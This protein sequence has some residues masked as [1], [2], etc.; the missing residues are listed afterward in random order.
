MTTKAPTTT[1]GGLSVAVVRKRIKNLHVGVYPPEGR[2]RVAAPLALSEEAVRLAVIQ[3]SS[4]IK[5]QQARF[6]AQRRQSRREFVSGESHYFLG[7]RYRL[8][9]IYQ[10]GPSRVALH[11]LGRIDLI[12]S[13]QSDAAHRERVF[14]SWY[15]EQLS[16][17]CERMIERWADEL[18]VE[19]AQWSIKQMKT[20]WGSCNVD[21]RRI[22]L[23]L[24]L[25]KKPVHSLEYVIVHELAHLRARRHD[26]KFI[27]LMDQHMPAWR[28][29]RDELEE[30]PLGHEAWTV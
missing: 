29:Y 4:W 18:G 11:R 28:S 8:N 27:A 16:A 15:R 9:V 6:R 10:A 25:A 21:A 24:Q 1:I 30:A 7:R 3:K 13:P 5:R 26:E 14:F 2:V 19:I 20:K 22:W 23:N 17:M 12:V